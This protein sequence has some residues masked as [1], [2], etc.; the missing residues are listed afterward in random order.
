MITYAYA[1]YYV[2][3]DVVDDDDDDVDRDGDTWEEEQ[4]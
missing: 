4:W 2:D 3:D 1:N